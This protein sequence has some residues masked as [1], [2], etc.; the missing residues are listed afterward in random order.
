M[1]IL[2]PADAPRVVIVGGGLAG[3]AAAQALLEHGLRVSL[4]EAAKHLGGRAGSF[5]DQAT[6]Q[7]IDHCQHVALG[8]CTNYLAFCR[9]TGSQPLIECHR[10]I[11]FIGPGGARGMLRSTRGLPAPL[12]LLPS[13]ARLPF[14]TWQERWAAVRGVLALARLDPAACHQATFAQWLSMAGQPPRVIERFWQVILISALSERLDR[15]SLAAARKVVLE[16]L[17]AHPQASW[18]YRPRVPLATLYDEHVARWLQQRGLTL[19]RGTP[20]QA[21]LPRDGQAAGVLLASGQRIEAHHVL[22]AVPWRRVAALLP[23]EW[24]TLIDPHGQLATLPSAPI[25]SAHLWCDRPITPLPHAALVGRLSQWLFRR[26]LGTDASP[27]TMDSPL[28]EYHQVVISA[29]YELAGRPREAVISEIWDDL[30]VLFPAARQARLWRWQ[31]LSQPLAVFA[32]HPQVEPLRPPQKTPVPNLYLAGDWTRTGWPATM[33][34]AVRSGYLA[35]EA[36][37]AACG[38]PARLVQPALPQ[39]WLVGWLSGAGAEET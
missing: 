38:R 32:P 29:A 27:P 24:A 9:A 18:L 36:I 30:C 4:V 35:A 3:L 7:W 26:A 34:G 12:H 5:F 2:P 37:L 8:C 13:L 15:I 16:G 28:G 21:V 11:P 14:L 22:L 25:A 10:A 31:L 20:V 23:A 6:G 19:H 33:E 17:L 1:A 39:G